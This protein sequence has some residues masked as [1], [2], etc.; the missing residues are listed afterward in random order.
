[1]FFR[2]QTNL[3]GELQKEL[4]RRLSQLSGRPR[5]NGLYRHPFSHLLGDMDPEISAFSSA[6]MKDNCSKD[7]TPRNTSQKY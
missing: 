5:E 7:T 2:A 4:M 1:M 3:T 6:A